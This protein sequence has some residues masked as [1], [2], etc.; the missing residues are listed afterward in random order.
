MQSKTPAQRE[1]AY[2]ASGFARSGHLQTILPTLFRRVAGINWQRE[3]MNTADGDFIDLDWLNHGRD[4]VVVLCHGL[5]G[6]ADT[7]YMKGMARAFSAADWDVVGYHFRGCS[8]EPN[9]L[10]RAYHSGA[11]DDLTEVIDHVLSRGQFKQLALVG[12]SLG[13]NLILKYLGEPNDQRPAELCGGVAI[14]PPVDLSGCCDRLNQAQNWVYQQR[15]LRS[16][17]GKIIAKG[18]L[19][20]QALGVRTLPRCRSVREFDHRYTAPLHGFDGAEDY[21]RQNSAG[22]YLALID[23][24]A[25]LISALDDPFLGASCF[26]GRDQVNQQLQLLYS[27]HG[28]HV[29]F[30]QRHPSGSFWAELQCVEFLQAVA[31]Q[32][33]SPAAAS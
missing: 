14:S 27:Q 20:K 19:V 31:D 11:T 5:E 30:M 17:Q 28:G 23:Y 22:Q 4:R 29:S 7:H 15:F 10:A 21:Y 33:Q 3:R 1:S 8:G 9:L 25:L 12:F 32:W 26:P 16:L 6:S 18:E 13:G 2:Q 24:P